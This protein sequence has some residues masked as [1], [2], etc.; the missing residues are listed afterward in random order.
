MRER[1]Y[2]FIVGCLALYAL[3]FEMPIVI[4]VVCGFML[5]EGTTNLLITNLAVSAQVNIPHT[6]SVSI[7]P[8]VI[9]ESRFDFEAIRVWRIMVVVILILS[10]TIFK[11]QLWFMPWFVGFALI[12]AGLSGVCPM[13]IFLKTV[14]FK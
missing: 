4:Y 9:E 14:G 12:G 11:E 2:M 8:E 10:Y 5:F 3:Y 7:N 1:I 6:A 13:L